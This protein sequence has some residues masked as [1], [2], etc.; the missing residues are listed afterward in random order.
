MSRGVV[1][2]AAALFAVVGAPVAH[3]RP[4]GPAPGP[5]PSWLPQGVHATPLLEGRI[6]GQGAR[7]LA[8]GAA[9]DCASL[10]LAIRVA[11]QASAGPPP[12]DG[13]AG[14]WLTLSAPRDDGLRVLQVRASPAGA[15]AGLLTVWPASATQAA[16]DPPDWPAG[17]R[18]L[19]RLESRETGQ[20]ERTLIATTAL[21]PAQALAGLARFLAP[22]GLRLQPA[23]PTA[24]AGAGLAG[25]AYEA[26]AP[27]A[28]ASLYLE[29]RDGA[30]HLV[31]IIQGERP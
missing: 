27:G 8:L 6:D 23:A 18:V 30:T 2:I 17:V 3:E 16:A 13:R 4:A 29:P 31:L 24:A 15:C 5:A 26:H 7:I 22:A 11:W 20:R 14:P 28:R 10:L 25:R 19:R 21:P 9:T 12:V 1:P